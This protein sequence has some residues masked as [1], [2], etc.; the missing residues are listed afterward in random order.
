MAAGNIFFGVNGVD[1]VFD[2]VAFGR[3]GEKT[4]AV[5][6]ACGWSESGNKDAKFVPGEINQVEQNE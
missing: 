4:N 1:F 3:D 5:D 2:F 6:R